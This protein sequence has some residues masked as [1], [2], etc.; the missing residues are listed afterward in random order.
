[1]TSVWIL[2]EVEQTVHAHS[3]RYRQQYGDSLI[4]TQHEVIP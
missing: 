1:M 3:P 2:Y 4:I